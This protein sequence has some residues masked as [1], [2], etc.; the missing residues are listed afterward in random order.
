M[1][2]KKALVTGGAGFL[3]LLSSG[4]GDAMAKV[5]HLI[6]LM[7]KHHGCV[8]VL[9]HT[10]YFDSVSHPEF[11]RLHAD[12]LEYIHENDGAGISCREIVPFMGSTAIV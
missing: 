4:A 3:P 11:A 12:T 2:P 9:W 7:K 1:N 6:G 10:D 5:S 8:S